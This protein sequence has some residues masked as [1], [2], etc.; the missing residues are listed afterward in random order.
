MTF[1]MIRRNI[2]LYFRDK[3]MFFTSLITP[4]IL[5]VLYV[6]FLGNVFRDT[7]RQ[8]FEPY[9]GLSEELI[10]GCVGGQLTSSLLAVCCVTVSF[11]ANFIMVQD[12]ANGAARDFAVTP[13][14]ENRLAFSYYCATLLNALLVCLVATALCL[15]YVA[16]TGWYLSFWDV[17]RILLDVVL[18]VF[19]GT[20]LSSIINFFL[21]TQ[22][23]I[24]AVGSIVS[25]CYG[26]VCGAYM[27]ISQ[28]AP[29]LQK[30]LACL[31]GTYGTALLRNHALNGTFREM[32]RL[33]IPESAIAEMQ[34]AMDCRID[35]F[36]NSVS[37]PAM[38][39]ILVG[40]ILLLLGIY[41]L[42][43]RK[44]SAK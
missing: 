21:T 8:V 13:I 23:Q 42:M 37:V 25:S 34:K 39:G 30:A 35:F 31:P 32:R 9:G 14:S 10:E 26:F 29:G 7:F 2:L 40:T 4:G 33:G 12:K 27:P 1:S 38:Y 16:L 15:G 43:N 17:C 44:R 22:G 6:S 20:A 19:F 41:V 28:F 5:L 3:G 11:C 36:G 24:S 18:L